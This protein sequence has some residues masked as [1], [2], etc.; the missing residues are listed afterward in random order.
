MTSSLGL[1]WAIVGPLMTNV[2]GGDGN[3]RHFMDHLGPAVKSW[4][5]DMR[6]NQFN[7]ESERKEAV[8]QNVDEYVSHVD[9]DA[10]RKRRDEFILNSVQFKRS[11]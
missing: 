8:N 7:Y 11:N 10:V 6:E 9:L 3:F 1:W 4:G 2:L 5:D